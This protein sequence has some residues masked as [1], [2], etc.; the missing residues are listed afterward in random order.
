M[1]NSLN[2]SFL[3]SLNMWKYV[4][5]YHCN[6][7]PPIWKLKIPRIDPTIEGELSPHMKDIVTLLEWSL[8]D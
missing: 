8:S 7:L 2:S 3:I 6:T 1:I 4:I 5:V